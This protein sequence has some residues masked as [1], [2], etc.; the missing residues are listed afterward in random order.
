M[1]AVGSDADEQRERDRERDGVLW[2]ALVEASPDVV[3]VVDPTGT[4]LFTNRVTPPHAER[5]VVGRKL[6]EFAVGDAA[7]RLRAKLREVVETREAI[8][9]EHPGLRTDGTPGW[10]DVRAIPVVVDGVVERIVWNATDVSERQRAVERL[11]ASER[12]FRALVEHGSDCIVL[13]DPAGVIS[14]AS[15]AVRKALGYEPEELVGK[16]GLDFIHPDDRAAAY[17]AGRAS[18]TASRT[19]ANLRMLHRDGTWRWQEG[20]STNLLHDPAVRAV[21]SNR[22]DVTDRKREE[23][24]LAFQAD[25]LDQISQP[26]VAT[27]PGETIIYWNEAAERVF[28][29]TAEEAVGSTSSAL[30]RPRW[31]AASYEAMV[32]A[33][34]SRS[35]WQGEITVLSKA[36]AAVIIEASI[37]LV[38]DE[39]GTPLHAISV[40]QDTTL[41]RRLEEQLRQS[42]KMEAIGLLAGGVAHDFNNLLAV[43]LG[44]SELAARKLPAGHPVAGQLSEVFEAA[45]R[46]GE[47]TR[48]LLAFSRKQIIQLR[49]LD[50]GAQVDD[51]T[52]M[53]KRI[54][55]EDVELTVDRE[56][57]T[58]AVRA[59]PT[60]LEQVL[61]NLCTNARQAMPD[62]GRLRLSTR[63]V[64]FDAAFIALHPWAR[65]GSFAEIAV[66]DTGQGMDEATLAHIYEPF[67]TTKREG[68]GLGLATVY[69]IVQQHEGLLDVQSTPDAGTTFRVYLPLMVDARP[70]PPRSAEAGPTLQ[71]LRGSELV[72]IA[73]DEPSLREL[74]TVTLTE[75]GYRVIA[76]RD[77]A[78]AVR[79]FGDQAGEIALVLLDVVMPQ[80]DAREA[81]ERIRV[82]RPDVK[83]L[84]T[85]GYAP[86]ST[87]LAQLL[88]SGR[89]PVL[90][91][92]F[93]P[94]ALARMVRAAIDG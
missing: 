59:D 65:A 34:R 1:V 86:A 8:H 24:R 29:Y 68:T 73:E 55:G 58:L 17:A 88:E 61:L 25:V 52:R 54:V 41:R 67:F 40:M 39:A 22:R 48:K 64:T 63:A 26:V 91:K 32:E 62:G 74:V 89:V 47:L 28:G 20:T 18:E 77:G 9:Y 70:E 53:I 80:L 93:T 94:I 31:P 7:E 45:R 51:F 5:G 19:E 10:Y 38:R 78:E 44:F 50:V 46:G 6:W 90:E 82:I 56:P 4:V 66:T 76:A 16:M 69:G 71:E 2:R 12:R 43:I 37:R 11:E 42:Q 83:V 15:P 92:P 60:Q 30:L 87:R 75:L 81:Y 72:L 23:E 49:P 33:L 85:T 27:N 35:A 79:A 84:F 3:L 21:V 13:I 14:Y 36:G 57:R